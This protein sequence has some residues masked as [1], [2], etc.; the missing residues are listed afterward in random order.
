MMESLKAEL[1]QATALT[2]EG[3]AFSFP[4]A[5]LSEEEAAPLEAAVE[6]RFQGALSGRLVLAVSGKILRTLTGN[7]LGEGRE[8][9]RSLQFDALGELANVTC[10]NVLGMI[11]GKDKRCLLDAPRPVELGALTPP[12]GQKAAAVQVGLDGGRAEVLLVLD[13]LPA[14]VTGV[15]QP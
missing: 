10:G 6:V 7:M 14:P 4:S 9:T 1:F 3:L 15:T 2:F 8:I 11:G 5:E 12:A 13:R